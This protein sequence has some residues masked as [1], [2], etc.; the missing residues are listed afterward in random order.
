M[1]VAAH[2]AAVLV[3]SPFVAWALTRAAWTWRATRTAIVTW[4]A[5]GF[6]L[7]SWWAFRGRLDSRAP[8]VY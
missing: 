5:I 6:Q 7:V 2:L 1:I 3:A 8:V 4:Q